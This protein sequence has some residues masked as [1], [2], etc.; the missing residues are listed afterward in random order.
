VAAN[1]AVDRAA[2]GSLRYEAFVLWLEEGLIL[3]ISTEFTVVDVADLDSSLPTL[4]LSRK[5]PHKDPHVEISL[6]TEQRDNVF[7]V[8]TRC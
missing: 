5:D 3:V 6:K 4:L 8:A 7:A 1:W 2:E